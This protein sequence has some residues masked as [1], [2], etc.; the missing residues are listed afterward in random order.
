MLKSQGL[1]IEASQLESGAALKKLVI[2]SL[3]VALT[4]MLLKM[5]LEC[6]REIKAETV[7][8][9]QQIEF[10]ILM[11]SQLEGNTKKQQNPYKKSTLAWGTWAIARLSG[12]SGYK[13]HGPPGYISIKRGLDIFYNKYEGYLLAMNMISQKDVYKE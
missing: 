3:Q 6:K 2:L 9:N 10:I 1:E 13:S 8:T 5:S 7:F 11:L 4:T 12:W